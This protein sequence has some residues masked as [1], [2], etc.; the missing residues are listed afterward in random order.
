M[1]RRPGQSS[2]SIRQT[3]NYQIV[4]KVLSI[5]KHQENEYQN[6][7]EISPHTQQVITKKLKITNVGREDG[8]HEQHR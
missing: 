6:Y 2:L 7:N 1:G 4:E 8:T 3:N 5:T